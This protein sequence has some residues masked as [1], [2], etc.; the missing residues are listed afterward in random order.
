MVP[1][2]W[3]GGGGVR[4]GTPSSYDVRGQSCSSCASDYNSYSSSSSSDGLPSPSSAPRSPVSGTR[5][6]CPETRG[7]TRAYAPA[8]KVT[9]PLTSEEA[10]NAPPQPPPPPKKG[11]PKGSRDGECFPSR[12]P[13]HYFCATV[14]DSGLMMKQTGKCWIPPA[15]LTATLRR[16]AQ[17]SIE[18]HRH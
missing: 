1:L 5:E 17:T 8:T 14:P 16:S 11:F 13:A 3:G 6:H 18:A 9:T 15:F 12:R 2:V 4:R 10:R 7:V